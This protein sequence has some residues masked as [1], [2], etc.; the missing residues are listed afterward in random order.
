MISHSSPTITE[1]EVKAANSVLKSGFLSQGDF[2]KKFEEQFAKFIGRRFAVAV[3]SGT[4][5]LHLAL[6]SLKV[7]PQDEII[8]PSFVCTAVVM[9]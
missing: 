6:L 9:Y 4:S 7:K 8:I 3:N 1:E 2:T 5:A